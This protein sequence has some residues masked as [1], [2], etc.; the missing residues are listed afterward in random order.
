MNFLDQTINYLKKW[1]TFSVSQP[2]VTA[3]FPVNL[4]QALSSSDDS[5]RREQWE[6]YGSFCGLQAYQ[7]HS[8]Q[9]D[10]R[11]ENKRITSH[12]SD[13]HQS[14]P[15]T[16]TQTDMQTESICNKSGNRFL[17]LPPSSRVW[18]CEQLRPEPKDMES[19]FP[20]TNCAGLDS[21]WKQQHVNE[22]VVA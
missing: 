16:Y 14:K 22:S 4:D 1:I 19:S 13:L 3:I 17:S 15:Q 12:L 6:R 21:G 5:I 11:S 18:L 7:P 9:R 20:Q 10:T 2:I 8:W